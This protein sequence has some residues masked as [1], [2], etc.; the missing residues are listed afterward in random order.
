MILV[1]VIVSLVILALIYA[2]Q[3]PYLTNDDPSHYL[4]EP[5]IN[6]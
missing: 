5:V 3:H 1:A 6:K 2:L 4:L